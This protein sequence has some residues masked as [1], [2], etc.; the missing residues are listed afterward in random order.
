[1]ARPGRGSLRMCGRYSVTS[2]PAA[3][4]A[5]FRYD[6]LADFPPRYNI[7]PSQPIGI[8]RLLEGRRAFA[9]V[10]WGLL[11]SWVKDPRTF[12]PQINAR[13]ESV[14]DRPAFKA[15]MRYR[16]CL[17]PADG[18]YEWKREGDRKQPY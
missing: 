15:A 8:V 13:G 17:I 2:S 18:F 6:E 14:I 9:L 3:F 5:L 7:A 10:R 4:R 16:R 12:A 11:P 1:M